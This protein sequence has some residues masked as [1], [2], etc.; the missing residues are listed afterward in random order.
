VQALRISKAST[1]RGVRPDRHPVKNRAEI[2]GAARHTPC[3]MDDNDSGRRMK[4]DVKTKIKYKGQEYSSVEELPPEVRAAYEKA[5]ATGGASFNTKI[6]FNGQEYAS[7]DQMPAAQRKLY[8]YALKL[9]HDTEV[10]APAP[11]REAESAALLTSRQWRLVLLFAVL[12]VIAVVVFL[13]K[14]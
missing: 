10:I 3:I 8:Q 6:V 11:A 7:L 14:R 9:S 1:K 13:L 2:S 4:I 12:V 5:M